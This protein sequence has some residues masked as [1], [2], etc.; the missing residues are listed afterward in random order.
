MEG[1]L[2]GDSLLRGRFPTGNGD[3]ARL[4]YRL[5]TLNVVA[6]P[7]PVPPEPPVVTPPP[8]PPDTTPPPPGPGPNLV[9]TALDTRTATVANTGT[10]PAGPF[11]LTVVNWG[12]VRVPGLAA[13]ASQSVGY[14]A[15]T[16]CGGDY[17]AY[18]DSQNEVVELN[19]LDNTREILG[20]VC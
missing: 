11:N 1:H 10:G 20:V 18:A 12:I 17:R 3:R 13:G 9:I 5:S 4:T 2:R 16:N 15:G 6:P 7:P 19:E 14:Y 8:L